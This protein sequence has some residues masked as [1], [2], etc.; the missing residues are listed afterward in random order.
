MRERKRNR[1][2]EEGNKE[3]GGIYEQYMYHRLALY[4][5]Y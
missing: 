2:R 5:F 4:L 1:G 3:T